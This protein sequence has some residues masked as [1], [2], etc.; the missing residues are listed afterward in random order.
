MRWI[1]I[2]YANSESLKPIV[3]FTFNF[4]LLTFNLLVLSALVGLSVAGGRLLS[5]GVRLSFEQTRDDNTDI[6][7]LDLSQTLAVNLTRNPAPD[8]GAAWSPDGTRMAFIS[9]RAGQF[10]L[11]VMALGGAAR[12]LGE[13]QV[14]ASYRPVWSPDGR[15]IAYEVEVNNL[16]HIAIVEVDEPL[17]AGVNPRMLTASQTDDRFPVWSPDGTRLAFT[18]WREGNAEIYTINPDGSS[19]VNLTHDPGWDVSPAWSPDGTRIAFFGLRDRY[20]ELYVMDSAGGSAHQLTDAR[21][22]NNGNFWRA[23]LWSPDGEALA[24]QTV[25][26]GSPQMHVTAADGTGGYR[27][28]DEPALDGLPLWLSGGR[29]VIYVSALGSGSALFLDDGFGVRP[30]TPANV[31]SKAPT[32]WD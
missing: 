17:V 4:R 14:A 22:V 24:Y 5:D 20:R 29:G 19:L 3:M 7:A 11:Y 28:T 8:M 30:L 13:W 6:Y 18:S 12:R 2:I 25:V 31:V 23:P 32:R 9:A 21:E 10:Q 1:S 15:A 16:R 26:G 27:L